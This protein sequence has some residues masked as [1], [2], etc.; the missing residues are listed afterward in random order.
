MLLWQ[1]GLEQP[2]GMDK[3]EERLR[4]L[5]MIEIFNQSVPRPWAWTTRHLRAGLLVIVVAMFLGL[6]VCAKL[7]MGTQ[8][9]VPSNAPEK[10]LDAAGSPEQ[11]GGT[12]ALP[13]QEEH[14][15]P[16]KAQEVTRFFGFPITNSMIVSWVVALSVIIFAQSATRN[17]K[18]VPEG[19]QNLLE[20]LVEGLHKFLEAVI[21]EHLTKR[22][23]W[24]FATVF[25]FILCTNWVG[26]IPGIG[27]VGWGHQTSH[28]FQVEQAWL[29][30][31]NA[32]V[33]MTLAMAL[34]FFACWIVWALLLSTSS[35]MIFGIVSF[36]SHTSQDS[37]VCGLLIRIAVRQ[38]SVIC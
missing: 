16:P 33:N 5:A 12:K 27:S 4:D 35:I 28:G 14:A 29:R 22:T 3:V 7:G 17:M 19:A 38:S 21:G 23:F 10:V 30:G 25:I 31:A 8:A 11:R 24:F 13:E 15:L 26:L 32:D 37:S 34:V 2:I 6:T 18:Q 20:W 36:S 9:G 1:A